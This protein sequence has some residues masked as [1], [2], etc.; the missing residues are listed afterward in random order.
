MADKRIQDLPSLSP[1]DFNFS[2]DYIIVQK[3]DGGTYKMIAGQAMADINSGNSYVDTKTITMT[4]DD[5]KEFEFNAINLLSENTA[6]KID[7]STRVTHAVSPINTPT[8]TR[9]G[10]GV[11][12]TRL[13]SLIKREGESL[14]A[15]NNIGSSFSTSV[16]AFTNSWSTRSKTR[17][18]SGWAKLDYVAYIDTSSGTDVMKI[19]IKTDQTLATN[20]GR[21]T[22]G[23]H[24]ENYGLVNSIQMDST[25]FA[26]LRV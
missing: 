15:E 20:R 26:N 24:Y 10:V 14:I 9:N 2:A 18:D 1:E 13:F 16:A 17:S 6:W 23:G 25:I 19:T 4:Q 11:G 3:P 7:F 12:E 5:V 22:T 21:N 8:E